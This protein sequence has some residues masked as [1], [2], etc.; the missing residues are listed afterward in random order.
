MKTQEVLC[1]RLK[2]MR[3][4]RGMSTVEIANKLGISRPLYSK[5]E[6][7]KKEIKISTLESLALILDT[8][9]SFL[10]GETDIPE[11]TFEKEYIEAAGEI[12]KRNILDAVVDG[13]TKA[14]EEINKDDAIDMIKK[15]R[16]N[17]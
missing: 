14:N 13:I 4:I 3:D 2:L 11:L 5:I 10:L 15:Y 17:K 9:M 1:E 7:G 16:N 6:N 12:F 8:S